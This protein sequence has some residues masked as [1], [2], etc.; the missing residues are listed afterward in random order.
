LDPIKESAGEPT[1]SLCSVKFHSH[2]D[3]IRSHEEK[4]SRPPVTTGNGAFELIQSYRSPKP[5][6]NLSLKWIAAGDDACRSPSWCSSLP[7]RP[8]SSFSLIVASE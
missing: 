2:G 7:L 8:G 6:W 4:G 3:L 5:R 1:N